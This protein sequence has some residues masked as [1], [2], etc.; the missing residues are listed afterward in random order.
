MRSKEARAFPVSFPHLGLVFVIST[1]A[2]STA[3]R[4]SGGYTCATVLI[5]FSGSCVSGMNENLTRGFLFQSRVL[6]SPIP[7][8]KEVDC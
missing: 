4:P 1:C 3:P 5:S 6:R 8:S 7:I 2:P